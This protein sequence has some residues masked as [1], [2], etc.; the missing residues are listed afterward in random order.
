[1][2]QEIKQDRGVTVHQSTIVR[3]LSLSDLLESVIKSF[4]TIR[5]LLIGK[6]KQRLI[7]NLNQQYLKQLCALLKPFKH[8]VKSIQIGNGTVAFFCSNVL[9]YV[10]RSVAV[11]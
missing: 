7:M 6:E 8:I 5:K 10:E 3:W 2:N 9:R 1:M 4:K 11:I